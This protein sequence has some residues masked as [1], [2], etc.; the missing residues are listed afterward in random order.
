MYTNRHEM[1]SETDV[2]SLGLSDHSLTYMI[3]KGKKSK[4]KSCFIKARTYRHFDESNFKSDLEEADWTKVYTS[5]T[6]EESWT[7][8]KEVFV[9]IANK[10]APVMTIKV[11]ENSPP[12]FNENLRSLCLD[13]DYFMRKAHKSKN[14]VDFKRARQLRNQAN[15]LL[16]ETKKRYFDEQI[17]Q[18][19]NDSKALWKTLKKLLPSKNRDEIISEIKVGNETV[20]D[21]KNIANV[22]NRFF[23]NIGTEL[24]SKIKPPRNYTPPL[25]KTPSEPFTIELLNEVFV[26]KVL[27]GLDMTKST[28]ID[29]I[30]SKLLKAAASSIGKHLTHV[31]NVSISTGQL[32]TEWKTAKVTPIFKEGDKTDRNNYRPISILPI[33]TKILERAIHNQLYLFLCN[34]NL[35]ANCQSGFRK[36]HS[37]MTTLIHVTDYLQENADRGNGTGMLF[38]DLKKAFDTVDHDL[39]IEKLRKYGV[40]PSS[41]A[42]FRNYVKD[43]KQIVELG[44]TRSDWENIKTGVPQGSILGPLLF[45]IYIN[46]LPKAVKR[47]QVTL[48]ADDTALYISS[49]KA[50]EIQKWLQEDLVNLKDWFDFN[51]LTLNLKKTK[52]LQFSSSRKKP[53]FKDVKIS[54]DQESVERVEVFKYLGVWLDEKLNFSEHIHQ[55]SKK[56]NK[57]LGLLMRIRKNITKDTA[58]M[59]YKSLVVPHLEYC[60][61]I[62]DTCAGI[63]KDKI[64]KLQNRACKIILK[65]KK[66]AHTN[67]IHSKLRLWKLSERRRFHTACLAYKCKH[68]PQPTYLSNLYQQ[69]NQIH[70]HNTRQASNRDLFVVRNNTEA[71]KAMFRNRSI[72]LWNSLPAKVKNCQTY[73]SFKQRYV[74]WKNE[75][76]FHDSLK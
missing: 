58:L 72:P 44:D 22:M 71:G 62:W 69:V 53:D 31:L 25:I 12:Y 55:I 49:R 65:T 32:A 46:D 66:Q 73:T 4:P 20:Q 45:I 10:H 57:R 33:V 18:N 2:V 70:Q 30:P 16:N 67:D 68:N 63:L 3:R 6:T 41:L 52:F 35:L 14:E 34:H 5:N 38:L 28:G 26:V 8:F 51:K 54:L 1:V 23:C 60:D 36:F 64:Q 40:A 74:T 21:R 43:R 19:K 39:L 61:V 24:A 15:N 42:W 37:T 56:V 76:I 9:E 27:S 50:D 59:L 13:R 47:C 75:L 17:N 11:K 29:Q 7:A 48:Y